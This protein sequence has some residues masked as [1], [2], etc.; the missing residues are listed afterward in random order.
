MFRKACSDGG[1]RLFT[2]L[3]SLLALFWMEVLSLLD[4]VDRGVQDC[5]RLF[6][7]C[8]HSRIIVQGLTN[9]LQDDVGV[10]DIANEW[11]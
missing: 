4:D 10:T 6:T 5:D 8:P 3:S 9:S 1:E 11:E 2:F 7:V